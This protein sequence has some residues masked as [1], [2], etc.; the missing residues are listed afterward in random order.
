MSQG[1]NTRKETILGVILG[2]FVLGIVSDALAGGLIGHGRRHH[3][4]DFRGHHGQGFAGKGFCPQTRTTAEAPDDIIEKHNPLRPTREVLYAGE[5]LYLGDVQPVACKICHG[6]NGRG[7]NKGIR[8]LN[9]YHFAKKEDRRRFLSDFKIFHDKANL[10][11]QDIK[12]FVTGDQLERVIDF[13][14]AFK[15]I[16]QT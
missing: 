6:V 15:K 16:K 4:R 2:I 7:G 13:L 12:Q 3:L 9:E 11:K 1:P 14:S 10:D 8:L 5:S